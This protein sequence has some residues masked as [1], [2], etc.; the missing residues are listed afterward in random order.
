MIRA[1]VGVTARGVLG[2]RRSLVVVLF[3]A[4]PVLV[5][6]VVRAGGSTGDAVSLSADLLD[7]LVVRT[8]LPLVALVFGTA[9]LGSELDDGTAIHLLVKPVERWRIVLAKLVV[10]AVLTVG[11]AAA[12]TLVAGLVVGAGRGAER[13]VVASTVAVAVGGLVYA[14][15]FLALSL[16]TSRA[17]IVGL[18]YV[19][20]WE[21]ALGGLLEG[22]QAF[23]VRQYTLAIARLLAGGDGQAINV[24]LDPSTAIVLSAIVLAGAFGLAVRRLA[25]YEIHGTA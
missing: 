21:G 12:V 25:T 11:L 2:R 23:S 20:V 6:L 5:A 17:L 13:L 7:A 24:T 10:A 4:L 9:V 22:T 15:L 18:G 8:V 3:A 1:I 16:V 19:L 14:A